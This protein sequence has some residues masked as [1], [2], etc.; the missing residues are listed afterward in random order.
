MLPYVVQCAG[1]FLG[2]GVEGW[3]VYTRVCSVCV[4]LSSHGQWAS[5]GAWVFLSAKGSLVLPRNHRLESWLENQLNSQGA[6]VT[7]VEG[8]GMRLHQAPP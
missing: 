6:S 8:L 2:E 3:L 7:G 1:T 5:L 4:C